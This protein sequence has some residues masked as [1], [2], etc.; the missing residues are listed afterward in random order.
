MN[1]LSLHLNACNYLATRPVVTHS[2]PIGVSVTGGEVGH[3]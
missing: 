2:H 3:E 1:D